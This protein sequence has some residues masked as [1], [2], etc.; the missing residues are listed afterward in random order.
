MR[1]SAVKGQVYKI[2]EDLYTAPFKKGDLVVALEDN[3]SFPW[4][5]SID[6]YNPE[7]ELYEYFNE[8]T[9]GQPSNA[10]MTN[11]SAKM[12]LKV[13]S[14]VDEIWPVGGYDAVRRSI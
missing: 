1:D 7:W 2:L 6:L 8:L 3:T 13:L 4:C 10:A 14:M 12:F 11:S 5:V 9:Y